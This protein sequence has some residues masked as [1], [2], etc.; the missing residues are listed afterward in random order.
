MGN[1]KYFINLTITFYYY[2]CRLKIFEYKT[3]GNKVPA[4]SILLEAIHDQWLKDFGGFSNRLG[5]CV[6]GDVVLAVLE[7]L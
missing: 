6:F 3:A 7:W 5:M 4:G 2:H 1:S